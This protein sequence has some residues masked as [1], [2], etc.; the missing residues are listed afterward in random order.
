MSAATM[1]SRPRSCFS[2]ARWSMVC[3]DQAGGVEPGGRRR[4]RRPA[5]YRGSGRRRPGSAG[6]SR[7]SGTRKFGEGGA[8]RD[9][10]PGADFIGDDAKR[11]FGDAS[12]NPRDHFGMYGVSVQHSW[13]EVAA[14]R[15]AAWVDRYNNRRFHNTLGMVRP[16]SS[17]RRIALP[18]H[19]RTAHAR[20]ARARDAPAPENQQPAALQPAT[21]HGGLHHDA[22]LLTLA[23]RHPRRAADLV[24]V[25]G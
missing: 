13:C 19:R 10:F 8:E 5:R 22:D 24:E 20:P 14:E 21:D 2:A 3:G 23:H 7:C 6:G 16:S 25:T 9:G 1:T 15:G 12:T 18:S 4:S 17:S 11:G